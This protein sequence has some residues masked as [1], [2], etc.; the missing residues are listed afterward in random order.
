[1]TSTSVKDIGSAFANLYANS[2]Q[3]TSPAAGTTSFQQVFNNQVSKED[4]MPATDVQTTPKDTDQE[5][6][7][8]EAENQAGEVKE[9][10]EETVKETDME[11]TTV[12]NTVKTQ[13]ETET[14]G[15]ENSGLSD[16]EMK[17]AMEVL[18]TAAMELMQTVADTFGMTLEELQVT[19]DELGM[20]AV[21]VLDGAKLGELVL[22]LG[23][24]SDSYALVTD[25][26]LYESYRM[27]MNEQQT[28]LETVAKELNL[29]P[30]ELKEMIATGL[31]SKDVVVEELSD[32]LPIQDTEPEATANV[33]ETS[34]EVT[35]VNSTEETGQNATQEQTED[36]Q[37]NHRQADEKVVAGEN[38]VTKQNP[39]IINQNV[40]VDNF[41]PELQQA[42]NVN[43][44]T[45]GTAWTEDTQQIM[46][47]IMDY[48]KVQVNAETTNLEMQLHPASLGTVRVNLASTGGV[49]TANF[50]AENETV[51]AALESQLVQ[52][53]ESFAEQGVKVEAIEVTVQTHAFEQN[54]EQGRGQNAQ[55]NGARRNR[56]R[57]INLNDPLTME[58]IDEEDALA[59]EMLTAG[60]STVDY[61]A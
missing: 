46:R 16:E 57:R 43:V 22:Q 58:N 31:Q 11:E 7:T 49:V 35:T 27:L 45:A 30:T 60:G 13:P 3:S 4:D 1:M 52:L 40:N 39:E 42:E 20:D 50:I 14:S 54:L 15:E 25:E 56:T 44:S 26:K 29:E 59:A 23:G 34:E 10:V 36:G 53:R 33:V 28:T 8:P 55:E 32:E 41:R 24:A 17:A 2:A 5:I 18:N 38:A 21:D 61:T 6:E 47:Q 19:M 51:K 12:E 9:R 37:T 48:M